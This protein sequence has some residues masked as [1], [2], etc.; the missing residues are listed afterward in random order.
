VARGRLSRSS[1]SLPVVRSNSAFC[2]SATASTISSVE[3]GPVS[4]TSPAST[5]SSASLP[6]PLVSHA[7]TEVIEPPPNLAFSAFDAARL[8]SVNA[9]WS[10]ADEAARTTTQNASSLSASVRRRRALPALCA[11]RA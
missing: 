10:A 6:A 9:A 5:L 4:S 8:T 2:A 3:S 11:A 7:N 1:L